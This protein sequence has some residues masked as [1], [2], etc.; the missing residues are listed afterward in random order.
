MGKGR[1]VGDAGHIQNVIMENEAQHN[2]RH[3]FFVVV[4]VC[5]PRS[6]PKAFGRYS[7]ERK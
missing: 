6:K 2:V 5:E 7:D 4:A 3:Y 1:G